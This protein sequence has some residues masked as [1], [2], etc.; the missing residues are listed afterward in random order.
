MSALNARKVCPSLLLVQ[1]ETPGRV[2]E[3]TRDLTLIGRNPD[4]DITLAVEAVSRRHAQ[5]IRDGD[6]LFV[7]DLDSRNYS[8]LD[9]ER[10]PPF[11]PRL[12]K[13]GCEIQICRFKLVF[14]NQVVRFQENEPSDSTILGMLDAAVEARHVVES[15]P[16]EKLRAILEI[17]RDLRDTLSL[18]DVFERSLATL[19]KIFPQADRGFVLM[20]ESKESTSVS[21]LSPQAIRHRFPPGE[22]MA[23]S[24][25]V[26]DRVMNDGKAILS[27]NIATD[28]R[29]LQ[30]QS[31]S[32][33]AIRTMLCVPLFDRERGPIGILQID[34]ADASARFNQDDLDILLAVAGHVGMAV[35][36]I[37]LHEDLMRRG[38]IEQ[39]ARDAWQV[40]K[41]LLPEH[42]PDPT[43]YEFWDCYE[44]AQFVG[45]DYFDYLKLDDGG[46][47]PSRWA[48]AMA[49][50][51][52]KGMPAALMMVKL[53]TEF[54]LFAA[55]EEDPI[56]V[57][58]CLNHQLCD[59]GF[60][61]KFVTF[62]LVILDVEH[63]RLTVVNAGHMPPLIRRADG[64]VEEI[65]RGESGTPL[66]VD[67]DRKYEAVVTNLELGDVV[68]F[69]TD[70]VTD[71]LNPHEEDFGGGRLRETIRKAEGRPKKIGGTVLRAV[72]GH[73]AGHSPHDDITLLCFGRVDPAT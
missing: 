73:A 11:Q 62:L 56:V 22:N 61:D 27:V 33:G 21:A 31:V 8:F 26:V 18:K 70:G 16:E 3:L 58:E 32:G 46:D 34:T 15:R 28:E 68:V 63:H 14:N 35:D 47:R 1:N 6:R 19:F 51:S 38:R 12:L 25:T 64:R 45:G 40:Q 44:P 50:V 72:R 49:D 59:G 17:G 5:I 66:A 23:V 24:R 65:G 71:A 48:L 10:I 13:D 69:Y 29:F 55:R 39:G 36:N 43:G 4:C 53:A 20:R 41:T 7:E 9:G 30:S 67:R 54:R 42:S 52:G 57:I 2:F 60:R 37:Y